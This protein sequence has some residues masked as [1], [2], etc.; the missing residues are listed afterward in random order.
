MASFF[1]IVCS[2]S[3]HAIICIPLKI[4]TQKSKKLCNPTKEN[5]LEKYDKKLL[6]T[7]YR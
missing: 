6:T 1:S 2:R 4:V 7:N 3:V 5:N